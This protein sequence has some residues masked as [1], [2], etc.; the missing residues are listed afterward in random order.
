L[1]LAAGTRLGPYEI[2]S[3]IGAGGM[4]EVYGARDTRLDRSVAIKLLPPDLSADPERRARFEREAKTIAGLNHPHICTLHDVGDHD[5]SMFLVMEHVV[6]DTL[7]ARLQKGPLPLEQALAVAAEIADALAAA[8]R[9]G[10]IHRDLKPGNVMLTKAGAKLLDFGLA[11]LQPSGAALA[12]VTMSAAPTQE[13]ATGAGTILGTVPYMAPEQLE[14]KETDARSDLFAFGAMLYE[15]LTGRRAFQGDSHVSVMAAIL[16]REPPPPSSVQPVTPPAVDCLVRQ[17]L[18]KAPD[19][20]PD[21]AHDVAN[22]LRWM[23]VTSGVGMVDPTR[24]GRVRRALVVFAVAGACAAAIAGAGLMWLLRPV[25]P[26][27][28]PVRL[29]L[30]VRPAENLDSG[31]VSTVYTAG[32]SRTALTWTPDGQALVFVGRRSGVQQLYVRRLDAAEARPLKGTEGAQA[33]TV[34]PDGQ[35]VAFW[36]NGAIRKVPLADGPVVDLTT[37]FGYPPYGL[38]WDDLGGLFFGGAIKGTIR[39]VA[40]D[41][42]VK[43]VT[44]LRE[45][46]LRHSLPWPLPGGRVVLYTIR[47]RLWS[48]GDEQ[49]V[50]ETVATG[51]RKVLLTNAA[52][53]RYV[54]TGHLVFLRQ[55]RLFAVSFD[56]KRVEVSGK[57]VPV[58]DDVAQVLTARQGDDITGAGQFAV[59]ATGILA[60]VPSP[61]MPYPD[62]SLVTV[63]R[64]GQVTPL[65]APPRS[66]AFC[67]RISRSD[68]RRLAVLIRDLRETGVWVYDLDRGGLIPVRRWGEAMWPQ[69]SP[70]GRSLVFSWRAGGKA[71]LAIQPSDA[72]SAT[73][74]QRLVEG[75]LMPSSFTP[76]GRQIAALQG[77]KIVLVDVQNGNASVRS[78][79]ETRNAESYPE[80][81]PD[82]RWLALVSNV[83]GRP[84][85]HVRAYP[86]PGP[87]Q[88]VSIEGGESPAWNPNGTELFFITPAEADKRRMMVAEF[89]PGS[90]GSPPR[91]GRPRPLFPFD[92]YDLGFASWPIRCYDVAPDGQRFFVVQERPAPP[93]PP[94][95][96]VNVVLNWFE[97]L[98]AKVPTPR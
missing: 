7:A 70:N 81:S 40:V 29:S 69:W 4:G 26:S 32:G 14:G 86:G 63:D 93:V 19:D 33:P 87:E 43:D 8:H 62:M 17:C 25:S 89:T 83:S 27:A 61:V 76:D 67:M 98:K 5:G 36:A 49:V 82:G 16:E 71:A 73:S 56:P 31:S 80:L 90:A 48:W 35:W 30:D 52:D 13:P 18:A 79:R 64:Q 38:V 50:A 85:V 91:I 1:S 92:Q 53:A 84:E 77:G 21:T 6:G 47:K 24:T 68:G 65:P 75:D 39:R 22:D 55:G 46:E 15:M 58:L 37:G 12:S 72:D 42:A 2:T 28:A 74:P 88:Q 78:L 59:S 57:P 51:E 10:I 44:T 3:L 66:Y 20:R 41:G 95:T 97:E 11:K 34:S 60:W 54:P 94:V 96:H 9:Q 23:Q 45:G